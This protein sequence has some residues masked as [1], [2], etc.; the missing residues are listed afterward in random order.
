[1]VHKATD[2]R[3]RQFA[4]KFLTAN[5]AMKPSIM[6]RFRQAASAQSALDHPNIVRVHRMTKPDEAPDREGVVMDLIIGHALEDELSDGHP[7]P[8]NFHEVMAVMGPVLE[9]VSCA[10]GHK[11]GP[12]VHRDLKPANVLL[13]RQP[14]QL[15]PGIPYLIDFDLVK[16]S[17]KELQSFTQDGTKM[18]TPPYMA[19][20]QY[21]ARKKIDERAD[22]FA[23]GIMFRQ[24]LTGILPVNPNNQVALTRLYTGE[25]P[26]ESISEHATALSP[27]IVRV[28]DAAV[29]ISPRGRPPNAGALLDALRSAAAGPATPYPMGSIDPVPSGADTPMPVNADALDSHLEYHGASGSSAPWILLIFGLIAAAMFAAFM[30]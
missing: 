29:C 26:I 1:M 14:G 23:L 22:V 5:F 21:M 2:E 30:K 25:R 24:L 13:A 17:G 20:E 3:G 10:H 6:R 12:I 4:V 15:W 16:L 18:G 9:A 19:P 11:D 8:W 28:L 27:E 7:P